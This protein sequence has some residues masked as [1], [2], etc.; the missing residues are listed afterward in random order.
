MIFFFQFFSFF[1]P[2]LFVQRN[3]ILSWTQRSPFT[4]VTVAKETPMASNS[5][6]PFLL[7]QNQSND[8]AL[9]HE[10]IFDRTDVRTIFI[11]MYG[12]VFCCCFCGKFY[13]WLL[14]WVFFCSLPP[15]I[16]FVEEFIFFLSY[17]FSYP[18]IENE[19][20]IWILTSLTH[21]T[22]Y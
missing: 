3:A 2:F 14:A 13:E 8:E 6:M 10:Y 7:L 1:R 4:M 9:Q 16:S 21:E 12:I 11:V 18:K 15:S 22:I 20:E 17:S 19:N 5:T